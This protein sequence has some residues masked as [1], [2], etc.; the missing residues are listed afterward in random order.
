M[1]LLSLR[2]EARNPKGKKSVKE[3]HNPNMKQTKLR[4]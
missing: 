1:F 2:K 4:A 3:T